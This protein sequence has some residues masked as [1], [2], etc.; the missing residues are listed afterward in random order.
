M[1][2]SYQGN[3]SER[4]VAWWGDIEQAWCWDRF[5]D[6]CIIHFFIQLKRYT[7]DGPIWE[8]CYILIF[9]HFCAINCHIL[10]FF[11]WKLGFC[12]VYLIITFW[13]FFPPWKTRKAFFKKQANCDGHTQQRTEVLPFTWRTFLK[14][15]PWTTFSYCRWIFN[16]RTPL[17]MGPGIFVLF[18]YFF[19]F[20]GGE[21]VTSEG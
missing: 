6:E 10:G 21:G 19:L 9:S 8:F 2:G 1:S 7:G 13:D 20:Y 18:V 15:F 14:N 4:R 11:S 17:A 12:F 16:V 3:G 5:N